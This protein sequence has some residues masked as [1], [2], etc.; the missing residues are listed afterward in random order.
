MNEFAEASVDGPLLRDHADHDHE[1]E[2]R[3]ILN[4]CVC[5]DLSQVLS[6]SVRALLRSARGAIFVE[7]TGL[8]AVGQVAETVSAA[9]EDSQARRSSHLASVIAVI[10]ARALSREASLSRRTRQEIDAADTIILNKVDMLP[11]GR[12]DALV[13]RIQ[14]ANRHARVFPATYGDVSP[15]HLLSPTDRAAVTT[16]STPKQRHVSTDGFV[17]VTAQVLGN[18]VVPRFERL[19]TKN[20]RKLARVKGF[21]RTAGARGLHELQWVPGALD[22][23]PCRRARGLREQLVIV[24]TR[25][26]DWDRFTTELDGCIEAPVAERKAGGAR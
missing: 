11:S 14:A 17:S 10:D 2:M 26:V 20:R 9:V 21:V 4:G 5:C 25:A 1:F 15:A 22:I 24:G 3:E 18:V 23:R 12:A 19:L 6:D 7:T 16:R 8:A 13:A